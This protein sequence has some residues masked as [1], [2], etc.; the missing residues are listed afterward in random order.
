M[1]TIILQIA[2]LVLKVGQLFHKKK[3]K[4]SEYRKDIEQ[5][6]DDPVGAFDNMF[7]GGVRDDRPKG[8]DAHT[9]GQTGTDPAAKP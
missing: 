5:I 3:D 7:G 2:N 4:R 8:E 6:K 9:A 1:W